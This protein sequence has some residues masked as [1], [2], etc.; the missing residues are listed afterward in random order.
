MPA[1]KAGEWTNAFIKTPK[2][3]RSF[4]MSEIR[5]ALS[6]LV[7]RNPHR[8]LPI[9]LGSFRREERNHAPKIF[10]GQLYVHCGSKNLSKI[11]KMKHYAIF[12]IKITENTAEVF[13]ISM[14][15]S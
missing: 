12:F 5:Y 4:Q 3:A 2:I 6:R 14:V 10:Q 13:Q 9:L 15:V 8:R 1:S 11:H 7:F